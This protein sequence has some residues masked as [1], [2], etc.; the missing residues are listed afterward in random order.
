MHSAP[1]EDPKVPLHEAFAGFRFTGSLRPGT[2]SPTR[3]VP[4][5]IGRPDYA[6]DGIPRSEMST[7]KNGAPEVK[8]AADIEA[9]RLVCK[10]AREV[11]DIAASQ[12]KAGMTTDD[13]DRIVHDATIA[14]NAYPSPLNYNGY[15]KSCCTSVNEVICHGIP[16]SHVLTDGEILNIDVTV[17]YGGFHGDV[18]E[19][20]F[21]GEPDPQSKVLVD[22]TYESLQKGMEIC[23]P[24]VLYREVGEVI[25]RVVHKHG[26]SVVKSY[27]GHGIGRLFHCA[28]N[29]PHYA[30]NKAVGTMRAGH[31][32]T[33]EPMINQGTWRDTLWPDNWTSCT[34]DGKRSAQFE[35]TILITDTGYEVL[36]ARKKGSYIDRFV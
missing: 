4:T 27:C 15:P 16:D 8:S 1:R 19:T 35:H 2:Y 26:L 7:N 32:F 17:Y 20:V 25:S 9:L 22:A 29:V 13:I 30:R 24:G 21:I 6:Y 33:I 12:A 18:N 5:H 23:K 31:V 36:T 10:M 14:R 34:E 3:V 11:L 28:P